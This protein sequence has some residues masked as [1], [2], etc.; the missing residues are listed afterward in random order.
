MIENRDVVIIGAGTAGLSALREVRKQT[1]NFT[2]VNAG[3]YGTT[4]A[5]VGCMPSKVLI[6]AANQFF[7]RNEFATLGI[8][9]AQHLQ[10]DVP[11]VLQRVRQ[12]RD[13]FVAGIVG[14]TDDLGERSIAGRA[15]LL[16]PDEVLVGERHLRAKR[17]IIATGS[18]PVMP[19]QWRQLRGPVFTSDTLFEARDLPRRMAVI[20]LGAVGLEIAQA[21]SRLGIR[22][23]AFGKGTTV[24]GLEDPIVNQRAVELLRAEVVV[25]MGSHATLHEDAAGLQ[26]RW[27][28][29]VTT[30]D[31]VVAALGRQP[32]IE[33]LGLDLLGVALDEHGMPE[34]NR[35][36]MQIGDLPVFLAGDVTNDLPILHVANDEGHVA[37]YNAVREHPTCFQRRTPLTI[38]FSDPNIVSVGAQLSELDT[39]TIV[40]GAV[41]FTR[42]GRARIAQE[43]RGLLRVYADRKDGLIR[44]AQL[45][46]PRGEHLAHLLA[47][48]I[49]QHATVH[50][51]LRMPIYH[52]AFEEG[53]RTALSDAARQ[54]APRVDS[55][56]A[57]CDPLGA[58]A[59]D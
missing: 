53:L 33:D 52:P 22:I 18:R 36:T 59:L 26:V 2:I 8:T 40:I 49:E 29:Q 13:E 37:G 4:C 6:E 56:L 31:A 48:A 39:A 27:E 19:A 23:T 51:L 41:D 15:R 28:D 45:C 3:P 25:R 12:L 9:G 44:G 35:H 5:R 17:I 14:L 11:A 16:A 50:S 30:V 54:I 24:G 7:R 46:A 32:N 43:N 42:Q 38:V 58:A 21:L 20:G 57:A 1:G 47:L 34:V 55:D 10:V